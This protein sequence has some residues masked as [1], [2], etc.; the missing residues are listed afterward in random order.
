MALHTVD[1][2]PEQ[3]RSEDVYTS[4]LAVGSL[5]RRRMPERGTPGR[6]VYA[7]LRDELML[8][9]NSRQ[10]LATFCTTW[11]EPEVRQLM[12]DA[13]DKNMIDKDEYPADRRD[14]VPLRPHPG[15]SLALARRRRDDRLLHDGIERSRDARR[16]RAEVAVARAACRGTASRPIVRTSSAGR[17]RCAGRSSPATSTSSCARS[18]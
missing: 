15:R 9:G 18:R 10:N 17:C 14:R 4:D 7:L 5:P 6:I 12:A 16:T 1:K 2:T 3:Q 8:D 11:V 13:I